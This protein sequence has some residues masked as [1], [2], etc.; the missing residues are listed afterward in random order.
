MLKRYGP[1]HWW[2]ADSRFEVML[3]AILTQN[4]AW[5]N[6]ERAIH[7]LKDNNCLDAQCIIELPHD[8]LAQ[9]IRPSGYFNIK[10]KRLKSFCDWYVSSGGYEKL[11]HLKTAALRKRL[12][13]VNGIGPETADDILLYA[14]NRQVFVVDAYT[15]RI[16]Q[17][18]G[19]LEGGESYAAVQQLFGSK[20][21][22]EPLKVFNEYHALIVQHAKQACRKK[23]L[24]NECCLSRLC[25]FESD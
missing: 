15:H 8:A 1:Q 16:F 21:Q 20:L 12:L 22:Q 18:L 19:V 9:L 23:P 5:I 24:C 2:P 25:E 7:N 3:G 11:K 13:A 14:F 4:T 17:R 6:V 10:A